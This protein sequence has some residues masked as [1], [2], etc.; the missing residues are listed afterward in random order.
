MLIELNKCFN[1]VVE[2]QRDL[3]KTLIQRLKEE[4][5]R[6]YQEAIIKQNE[7]MIRQQAIQ[8]F[9]NNMNQIQR[10]QQ[11]QNINN[12]LQWQNFH[13]QNINNSIRGF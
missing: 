11:L 12:N 10:N 4:R 1:S 7:V 5:D 13:L 3:N 9:T 8:N 6:A 2:K